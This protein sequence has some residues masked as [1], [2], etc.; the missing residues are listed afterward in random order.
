MNSDSMVETV[1]NLFKDF[2]AK[3]LEL[4]PDL[5]LT[6]I[7]FV[8]GLIIA[9]IIQKLVR[10]FILYL[11]RNINARLESKSF[12]VDLQSIA[13]LLSRTFYWVIIILTIAIVTNVLG[14]PVLTTWLDGLVVYLPNI[15]AGILIVFIGMI[16]GKLIGDLVASGSSRSGITNAGQ[17]G[18]FVRYI[19]VIISLLIAIDQIGISSYPRLF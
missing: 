8:L 16:V 5:I 11:D 19:V 4:I 14:M 9:W 18:N 10:K 2:Y 3:F 1:S 13:I 15:L 6:T 7:L 17:L 12:G